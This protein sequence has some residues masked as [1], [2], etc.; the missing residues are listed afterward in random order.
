MITEVLLVTLGAINAP[1]LEIVPALADQVT[2]VS[3]VPLMLAV[4]CCCPSDATVALTGEIESTVPERLAE[5]TIRVGIEP[6]TFPGR[7]ERC[8]IDPYS[9]PVRVET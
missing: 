1:M 8:G 6:Y 7:V 5:T 3:A 9:F 2:A 4:N